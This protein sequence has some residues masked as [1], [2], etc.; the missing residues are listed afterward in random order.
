[1]K[2]KG[3]AGCVRGNA[4][5]AYTYAYDAEGMTTNAISREAC[6][7]K[8]DPKITQRLEELEAV[9]SLMVGGCNR[10]NYYLI[11]D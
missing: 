3:L 8:K 9:S 4:T 6:L 2:P 10:L 1:M 11:Q 5:A 7:L